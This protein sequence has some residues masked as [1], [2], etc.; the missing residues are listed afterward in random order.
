MNDAD[1]ISHGYSL[2]AIKKELEKTDIV[3]S[4]RHIRR[5]QRRR[6]SDRFNNI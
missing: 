4:N 5:E 3:C 6:G 1:M 2:A